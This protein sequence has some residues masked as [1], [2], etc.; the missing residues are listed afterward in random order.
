MKFSIQNCLNAEFIQRNGWK[1]S[2]N[3]LNEILQKKKHIYNRNWH[4][5]LYLEERRLMG[6]ITFSAKCN[7]TNFH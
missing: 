3:I 1:L 4:A 6:T 5:Q 2:L 7:F